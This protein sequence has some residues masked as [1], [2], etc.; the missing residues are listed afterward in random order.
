MKS[1]VLLASLLSMSTVLSAC[2]ET[3]NAERPRLN[4]TDRF[5]TGS[6]QP[7]REDVNQRIWWRAFDDPVLD[8]LIRRGMVENVSIQ[9]ARHRLDIARLREVLA[10]STYLPQIQAGASASRSLDRV[11][12][13]GTPQTNYGAS[14][15][16][17][18]LIDLFGGG[19]A[20]RRESLANTSAAAADVEL[21]RLAFLADLAATYI[22]LRFNEQAINISKANLASIQ[23]TRNLT[24]EMRETGTASN[25]DIAQAQALVDDAKAQIPPYERNR[26][27]AINH[28]ATLLGTTNMEIARVTQGKS[29]QPRLAHRVETGFPAD[30][31][32]NRP[33]IRREERLLAAAAAR[34]DI[35]RSRLYPALSLNGTIDIARL[36]TSG[37]TAGTTSW[38]FGPS[39]LAPIFEG[40]RLRRQVDIQRAETRVQYLRW[41]DTVLR[42]VEEVE[43]AL[44]ALNRGEAETDA[45]RRKVASYG[46]ARDLARE[47]YIGGTGLILDILEAE[48]SLGE[49]R[50]DLAESVR[51]NAI[52]AV[53]LQVALGSGSAVELPDPHPAPSHSAMKAPQPT[54]QAPNVKPAQPGG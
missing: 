37:L 48:R 13:Q 16:F 12:G 51:A 39:L 53:R 7:M 14:A 22:D 3:K 23:K 33:D 41:K 5:T 40:G 28:L 42:A 36:I 34:I 31:L 11:D 18:M 27:Q 4:L 30:L 2:V 49:A 25:L 44:V 26:Q 6:I 8:A 20:A 21:V 32:R 19:R 43:N 50:L 38:A 29:K 15:T 9:Q 47:S 24:E 17:S 35:A 45:H 52:A 54:A 46:A 10:T 1:P